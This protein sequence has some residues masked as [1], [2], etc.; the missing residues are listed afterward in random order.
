[1]LAANTYDDDAGDDS[2]DDA[3]D[4]GDDGEE[5]VNC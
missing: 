1:M 4:E 5:V 2:D 3:G